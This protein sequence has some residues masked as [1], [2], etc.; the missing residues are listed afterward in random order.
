MFLFPWT[1]KGIT[2]PHENFFWPEALLP[3]EDKHEEA[4][5]PLD[6]MAAGYS[7]YVDDDNDDDDLDGDEDDEEGNGE[8]S[9]SN[10]TVGVWSD[11]FTHLHYILHETKSVYYMYRLL[12]L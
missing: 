11:Y 4:H 1:L 2:K 5:K 7:D 10:F 12:W 3:K 8:E 9:S 6:P